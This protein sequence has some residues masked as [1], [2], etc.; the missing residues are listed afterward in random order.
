MR[1]VS[2]RID[3]RITPDQY[4]SVQVNHAKIGDLVAKSRAI[5]GGADE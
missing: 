3:M 2:F 4:D 5:T 1:N